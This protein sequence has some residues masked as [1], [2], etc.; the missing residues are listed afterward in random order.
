MFNQPFVGEMM[1][2]ALFAVHTTTFRQ[3]NV[4]K[5]NIYELHYIFIINVCINIPQNMFYF[6]F[7]KT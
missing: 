6:P 4:H 5:S 7:C 1:C 3:P 2:C